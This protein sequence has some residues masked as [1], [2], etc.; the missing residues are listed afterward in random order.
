MDGAFAQFERAIFRERTKAGLPV[1]SRNQATHPRPVAIGP[2]PFLGER[3][4]DRVQDDQCEGRS[5]LYCTFVPLGVHETMLFD[6]GHG[7]YEWKK[8]SVGKS[9]SLGRFSICVRRVMG[10]PERAGER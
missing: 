7:F 6:S 4:Q 1:Q 2:D 9:L 8:F 10:R 5:D 3:F